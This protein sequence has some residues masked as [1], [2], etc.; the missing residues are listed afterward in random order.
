M[1]KATVLKQE[2]QHIRQTQALPL[3]QC[4]GLI[5][6]SVCATG[7][8]TEQY[9]YEITFTFYCQM[10][11]FKSGGKKI[12]AMKTYVLPVTYVGNKIALMTKWRES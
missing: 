11:R 4:S 9:V 3:E 7:K 10:H 8:K 2:T 5:R 1:Y 6:N 12:V